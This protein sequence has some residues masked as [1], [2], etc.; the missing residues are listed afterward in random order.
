MGE[1]IQMNA[2]IIG[3]YGTETIGDRGILA[4]IISM[5]A[6]YDSNLQ[7]QLGSLYPFFSKRTLSEDGE[8]YNIL[9]G[10]D[11]EVLLF[12]SKKKD[13][14]DNA[15]LKSDVLIMGG[16][17]LMDI[18]EMYMVRYAFKFAKRHKKKTVLF[19]CGVG[20]LF[21][22]NTQ[23]CALDIIEYA[24][25]IILRDSVS[26]NN[27]HE[28]ANLYHRNLTNK[29][30]HVSF[31]P[32]VECVYKSKKIIA[33]EQCWDKNENIAV[34]LRD[35]PL[36]YLKKKDGLCINNVN[37]LFV[38]LLGAICEVNNSLALIP[39][40]YFCVGNDDR[41]FLNSLCMSNQKLSNIYV[42][43][44]PL[45]LVDTMKVYYEANITVGMRFHS[46]VFQTV[47]NGRNF[48]LD[49]TEPDKGKINGFM[50]DVFKEMDYKDRYC[51]IQKSVPMGIELAKRVFSCKKIDMKIV[52]RYYEDGIKE[53]DAMLAELI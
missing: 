16:G 23:L 41:L 21:C 1:K 48:V 3:W 39:M 47:L 32:A 22:K 5:L 42:Q 26:L 36:E 31:D 25:Y 46:V 50:K 28:L 27:I 13:A 14:L 11:I 19:G 34:N 45:S 43:N 8:L 38:D 53:Y 18:D 52:D 17:P 30:I 10:Y 49:Y 24:D 37:D 7:I 33:K 4:G 9:A 2:C 44:H 35:F 12:G 40:H 29:N 15:I 20:P 6:K 51:N